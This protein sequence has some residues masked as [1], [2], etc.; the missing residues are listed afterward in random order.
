MAESSPVLINRDGALVRLILNRPD[1]LNALE[2]RMAALLSEYTNELR[3]DPEVRCV[4]IEGAGGQFMAGG[5]IAYF[6]QTLSLSARERESRMQVVFDDVNRLIRNIREMPAIV[7]ARVEG[8]AAGF[9]ISLLAACDLVIADEHTQFSIAYRHIGAT[10]DGGLS[11]HLSRQV[12]LKRAMQWILTGERFGA[13]Q[14]MQTGLINEVAESGQ[15][16]AVQTALLQSLLNGPAEVLGNSK[17]LLNGSMERSF[18]EQLEAETR[19]FISTM[20]SAEFAE[21]V[22]AFCEKR[23]AGFAQL[24][25]AGESD[26]DK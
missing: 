10:P 3:H 17:A 2:P 13:A 15:L 9:G 14:A 25:R 23:V 4:V 22:T 12:G 11:W 8:S 21:G 5:D 1:S 19:C 6:K 20:G 7:I 26:D 16:D 18:D 24:T